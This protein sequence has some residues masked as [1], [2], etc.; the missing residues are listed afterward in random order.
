[1]LLLSYDKLKSLYAK[2][3]QSFKIV[4][5]VAGR[6]KAQQTMGSSLADTKKV[7]VVAH[8]EHWADNFAVP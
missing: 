8:W 3:R 5:V 7:E 6:Y 2:P 4:L 1:M